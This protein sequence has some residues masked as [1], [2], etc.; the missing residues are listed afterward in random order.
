[1]KKNLVF[2]GKC[3]ELS[4][5]YDPELYC[6]K[7]SQMSFEWAEPMSLDRL[8]ESGIVANGRLYELQ[9]SERPT[10]APGGFVLPT[11]TASDVKR[12]KP[13]PADFKAEERG[14]GLSLPAKVFQQI[15]PTPTAR[16][17]GG[18]PHYPST[19][20]REEKHKMGMILGVKVCQA[21]S[22]T[23]EEAIGRGARL[24]PCFL[25]WMMGFPIGWTETQKENTTNA[26]KP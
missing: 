14:Y 19:W 9:I 16:L 15:F 13:S 21:L 10:A 7:T 4:A 11:P 2:G 20:I 5:N 1:M 17:P 23:K 24:N 6:W 3:S 18:H 25:E 26:C 8:P 12:F 22:I